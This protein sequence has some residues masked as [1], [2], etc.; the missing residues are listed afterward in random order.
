MY[1]D[2]YFINCIFLDIVILRLFWFFGYILEF[3]LMVEEKFILYC[4]LRDLLRCVIYV[5][6]IV[7]FI[8]IKY[9]LIV[10]IFKFNFGIKIDEL[11]VIKFK[12]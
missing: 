10:L 8:C 12:D 7:I 9:F 3:N 2:W 4:V 1:L 11:L 5:Y 6:C